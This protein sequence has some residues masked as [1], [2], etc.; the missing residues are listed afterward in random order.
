MPMK[1]VII[2]DEYHARE[3]LKMLIAE[4]CPE[5]HV[6][7]EGKDKASGLKA[8]QEHRPDVVFLD[9]R[10]PSGAE[11][12]EMLEECLERD[13]LV[14]FVTAFKDYAIEAFKVNAVDYLLKPIDVDELEQTGHRLSQRWSQ[15]AKDPKELTRYSE[16]LRTL[17]Q[18]ILGKNL[19][20]ALYHQHGIKLV[21]PEDILYLSADGSCTRLH[22]KDGQD[23]MDSR[24]LKTFEER[25]DVALFMRVHRSFII[26]LHELTEFI[27]E[28]GSQAIL[29]H[30]IR[31]P[32]SRSYAALLTARLRSL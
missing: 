11:G 10:M 25:L 2:D 32:V 8:I 18:D 20:L 22:F 15:M 3:N 26:N 19:R 28:D 14:V 4:Y 24:T 29:S 21:K 16:N 5:I 6:V 1:A 7:G 17:S 12:F 9:I 27:R 31:I 13:F 30:T 23:Y